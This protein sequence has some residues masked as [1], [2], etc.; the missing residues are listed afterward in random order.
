MPP[1]R[2]AET[3]D[4]Q[5]IDPVLRRRICGIVDQNVD[6]AE[7]P[8]NR[9]DGLAAGGLIGNVAREAEMRLSR[10]LAKASCGDLCGGAI[11]IEYCDAGPFRSEA[12]GRCEPNPAR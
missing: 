2:C 12:P 6:L 1:P 7:S 10:A 9:F 11:N 4:M 3:D 5:A 8:D